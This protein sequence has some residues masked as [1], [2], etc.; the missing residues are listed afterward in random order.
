MPC[1]L[2]S[3]FIALPLTVAALACT[4]Q[5]QVETQYAEDVDF[6]Q[7][8]TYRWITDDLVLIQPGTGDARIRSVDNE[9]RIRAA[10]DREL[11]RKGLRAAG[12]EQAELIVAFT[13]GTSVRYRIQGGA[14]YDIITD[15]AASYT[16][17]VL[18]IYLF[19]RASR[20]QIWSA[21]THEDLEPGDNP[22]AVINA[23][24]DLLLAG[25]PPAT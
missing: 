20:R 10:I 4:R 2:A 9:R 25:F 1:R 6:S 5:L 13:V 19:D 18:T 16:R 24:V 23:A 21:R 8:R 14:N 11:E 22:D 17:G 15:P 12:G 3:L 7:Y